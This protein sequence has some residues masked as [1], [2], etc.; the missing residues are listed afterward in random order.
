M[1]N[2]MKNKITLPWNEKILFEISSIDRKKVN[3]NNFEIPPLKQMK[4]LYRAITK[5]IYLNQGYV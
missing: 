5:K 3:S 4:E 1:I 2:Q